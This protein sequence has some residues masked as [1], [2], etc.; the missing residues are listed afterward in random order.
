MRKRGRAT[1]TAVKMCLGASILASGILAGVGPGAA[2][3][4]GP[5]YNGPPVH[6]PEDIVRLTYS[7]GTQ[8]LKLLTAQV[9]AIFP[10]GADHDTLTAALNPPLRVDGMKAMAKLL[11]NMENRPLY[12]ALL[13]AIYSSEKSSDIRAFIRKEF[14]TGYSRV[15]EWAP[16]VPERETLWSVILNS[17][18][19]F[20]HEE[21]L[22]DKFW[23]TAAAE[24]YRV[25]S[26][27]FLYA[28]PK[29]KLQLD[30][31]V[32]GLKSHDPD[33]V[34]VR[35]ATEL[36]DEIGIMLDFPELK[37][38][39]DRVLSG[40]L[41][42]LRQT[43]PADRKKEVK[44][45]MTGAL[46]QM[47]EEAKEACSQPTTLPTTTSTPAKGRVEASIYPAKTGAC[48]TTEWQLFA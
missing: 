39:N 12:F 42:E 47:K 29:A 28:S 41:R 5:A 22:T 3:P 6:S 20:G 46:E 48:Y 11:D 24:N 8:R 9:L 1:A 30:R 4:V 44:R 32:K 25:G 17:L 23:S 26:V 16:E 35:L 31:Y 45:L 19:V 34:E 14:D 40:V 36:R 2:E 7:S 43:P 15:V 13:G 21:L 10:A 27:L 33:D 37:A 38:L 18:E